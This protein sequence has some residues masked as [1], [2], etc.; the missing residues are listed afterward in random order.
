MSLVLQA[1]CQICLFS[2]GFTCLRSEGDSIQP[3]VWSGPGLEVCLHFWSAYMVVIPCWQETFWCI[4]GIGVG[5]PK[6]DHEGSQAQC[7]RSQ[8]PGLMAAL[9]SRLVYEAEAFLCQSLLMENTCLALVGSFW[10]PE[11][12]DSSQAK[13]GA[14]D[15]GGGFTWSCGG[16]P[17][18]AVLPRS[19]HSGWAAQ[20]MWELCNHPGQPAGHRATLPGKTN[21]LVC[22]KRLS[23]YLQCT[24]SCLDS[25]VSRWTGKN[26]TCGT[27]LLPVPATPMV[28]VRPRPEQTHGKGKGLGKEHH[29]FGCQ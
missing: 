2:K 3:C 21:I 27:V 15:S 24:K 9:F 20:R 22:L 23:C 28:W 1:C 17:L 4:F 11:M 16:V 6:R 14:A 8:V 7:P 29:S 25:F 12:S 18:P 19:R 26:L 10:I 13:Q 5:Q